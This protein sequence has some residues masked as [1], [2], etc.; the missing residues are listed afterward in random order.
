MR[1]RS[2]DCFDDYIK[3]NGI[4]VD[5]VSF[6][7]SDQIALLYHA[8]N[9]NISELHTMFHQIGVVFDDI[10]TFRED[11]ISYS[12]KNHV[13][14]LSK[15]S[16]GERFLLFLLACKKLNMMVI[17]IGLFERLGKRLINVV[18]DNLQDYNNLIILLVNTHLNKKFFP[19]KEN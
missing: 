5:G 3:F 8:V 17:A 14:S 13:L 6:L 11:Y 9:G 1:I 15:L 10:V 16:S 7:D 2:I 12:V 4:I 19:W 18:Y